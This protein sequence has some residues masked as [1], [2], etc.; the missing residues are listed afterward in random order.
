MGKERCHCRH[1]ALLQA[2][3]AVADSKANVTGTVKVT[4][5]EHMEVLDRSGDQ[6]RVDMLLFPEGMLLSC[7]AKIVPSLSGH[8]NFGSF[9]EAGKFCGL[10]IDR[11]Q[12]PSSDAS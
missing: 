4:A 8:N 9:C 10:I 11:T 3:A 12:M 2:F 6:S 1:P 5:Y 7:S